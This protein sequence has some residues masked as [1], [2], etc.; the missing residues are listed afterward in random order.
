MADDISRLEELLAAEDSDDELESEAEPKP[1]TQ[2]SEV[3]PTFLEDVLENELN[4]LT[5]KKKRVDKRK[6]LDESQD[7]NV[8]SIVH[9][10][11][12]DSSDDEDKK[13]HFERKYDDYGSSIKKLIEEKESNKS[14]NYREYNN[15][16]K[17]SSLSIRNVPDKNSKSC[18]PQVSKSADVYSD[19]VFG[20]RI[21]NPLISGAVLSERMQGRQPITMFQVKRHV[22]HGDISKDWVIGGVIVRRSATKESQKG[23]QYC[24]WTLSDLKGDLKTVAMFLFRNAH[25]EL[26]KT[27]EGTVVGV[28]NPNVLDKRDDSTDQACL[29]VDN[30]DRVMLLGKSKD[31]GHCKSKKRNGE[32]CTSF[33]NLYQCQYCVYHVKQ[34]YQ[35][36]SKRPDLQ[37]TNSNRGLQNLRNKILGTSP[38]VNY[39]SSSTPKNSKLLAAD[40]NR[41]QSLSDYFK[42]EDQDRLMINKATGPVQNKKSATHID[43]NRSQ[44]VK[45]LKRLDFLKG[46]SVEISES[47]LED[48]LK[49]S[50]VLQNS[51]ILNKPSSASPPSVGFSL[52]KTSTVDL[53]IP[54][55][56]KQSERAKMNALRWIKENGPLHKSNP[57]NVKGTTNGKKRL[58]ENSQEQSEEQSNKK[59]KTGVLSDDFQKMLK[60]SSSHANLVAEHDDSEQ[61]KYFKKLELKEAMEEK[62]LNTYKVAC[63]AVKCLKCSYV[64]FSASDNCKQNKHPLKVFDSFKR[65]FRCSHCGNRTTSLNVIPME[66]CKNCKSSKW[67]RAGMINEKKGLVMNTLSIRGEE[68]KFLGGAIQTGSNINLLVPED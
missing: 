43:I 24:I 29:S 13:N 39:R 58:L 57:H 61:D 47:P 45:D 67:I 41:L 10:G 49:N 59:L 31:F 60:A 27:T 12:T 7:N 26:W 1:T 3:H 16:D 55:S 37:A 62:M 68:E 34:E 25:K 51:P 35:K 53:T 6:S 20:I 18:T 50:S 36:C 54:Y 32:Q 22:A 63:K 52:K 5:T 28:L 64:S 9:T 2:A 17:K 14:S 33:V 46:S 23:A 65:F 15:I 19:P 44:R 42:S 4:V 30:P 40:K 21:S 11:D 66:S 48:V 56:K 38:G 8:A